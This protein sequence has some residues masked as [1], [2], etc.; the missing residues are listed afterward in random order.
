[1][2]KLILLS[3]LVCLCLSFTGCSKNFDNFDNIKTDG[4]LTYGTFLSTDWGMTEDEAFKAL[5][6]KKEDVK[7]LDSEIDENANYINYDPSKIKKY[8]ATINFNKNPLKIALS[9]TD[10]G[11]GIS[12]LTEVA[13]NVPDKEIRDLIVSAANNINEVGTS[14]TDL[15]AIQGVEEEIFYQSNDMYIDM[16]DE[17]KEKQ[18]ESLQKMWTEIGAT[19]IAVLG[20]VDQSTEA[21]FGTA[22]FNG[23]TL[24]Q[25]KALKT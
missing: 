25:I 1:M 3:L 9:F 4:D 17:D 24:V 12:A 6:V 22:F 16:A 19:R 18:F 8:E 2:K 20:E 11:N 13:F 7:I 21:P 10:V 15:L 14:V 5:G 23:Y